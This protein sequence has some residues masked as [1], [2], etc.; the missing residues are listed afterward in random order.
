V[1]YSNSTEDNVFMKI[2]HLGDTA[3][4]IKFA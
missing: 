4:I 1:R 2:E 3:N